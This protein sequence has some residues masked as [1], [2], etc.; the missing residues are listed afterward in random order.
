MLHATGDY[1]ARHPFGTSPGYLL[2]LRRSI[3]VNPFP[4]S[5]SYYCLV[6]LL[7]GKIEVVKEPVAPAITV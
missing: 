3:T 5:F 2:N 6:L 1:S 4:R 7:R